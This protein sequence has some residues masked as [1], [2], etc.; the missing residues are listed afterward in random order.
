MKYW[1][2]ISYTSADEGA[3][4]GLHRFLEGYSVPRLLVGQRNKLGEPVPQRLY[5]VF[6]DRDELGGS[7]S[8]PEALK[9]RLLESRWL[10]LICTRSTPFSRWVNE[11]VQYFIKTR[12][13]KYVIC[14]F[15]DGVNSTSMFAQLPDA[16]A[17]AED[18][19]LGVDL[20]GKEKVIVAR[21]RLVATLAGVEFA[22]LQNREAKRKRR[23]LAIS[24]ALVVTAGV[25]LVAF[26]IEQHRARES[27]VY[28]SALS[29][30][31]LPAESEDVAS[32]KENVRAADSPIVSWRGRRFLSS[33]GILKHA[34]ALDDADY[35]LDPVTNTLIVFSKDGGDSVSMLSFPSLV[36]LIGQTTVADGYALDYEA[37]VIRLGPRRYVVRA[38]TQSSYAG[39]SIPVLVVFDGV[40]RTV[41]VLGLE[42]QRNDIVVTTDCSSF[43]LLSFDK[44]NVLAVEKPDA[45]IMGKSWISWEDLADA[46][47]HVCTNLLPM[48]RRDE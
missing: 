8:L 37:P 29:S 36:T 20:S 28:A 43:S 7:A 19:P 33:N 12:G 16:L 24:A 15:P 26:V 13:R 34:S 40:G 10:V 31:G 9:E 23:Q 35:M 47:R 5:P 32:L 2:F 17:K 1:A 6:R 4:K 25:A 14:V 41:T 39:G 48:V 46:K 38:H 22:V 44:H 45:S 21:L 27:A 42:D 3:A 18:V 11:E 30:A